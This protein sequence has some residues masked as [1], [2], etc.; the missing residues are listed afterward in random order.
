MRV[1]FLR[2]KIYYI[3]YEIGRSKKIEYTEKTGSVSI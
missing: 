1:V 2:K 3:V